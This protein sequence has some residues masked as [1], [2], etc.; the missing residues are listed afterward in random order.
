MIRRELSQAS[1][2]SKTLAQRHLV[3]EEFHDL[4][5]QRDAPPSAHTDFY[6]SGVSEEHF[7]TLLEA[8]G[9]LVGKRVLD[10]G[11]GMGET[12]RLYAEKGAVRVEGFDISSENIRVA[13]KNTSRDGLDDRVF[14][15][16]LAA[17]EIDY[18]NDSFDIVIGKAIIHHTDLER[19]AWQLNRVLAPGGMA[20]FLEPLAHNPFLNLFRRLTPSRRTPTEKPLRVED[21]EIFER[22]FSVNYRGF[23]LLT[24]LAHLLLFVTGSR[25][26]FA[27]S[28]SLL[29]RWEEPMLIRFPRLQ[30]YCWSALLICRKPMRKQETAIV[31]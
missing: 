4:K 27:K 13:R 14:F 24:L 23:Y 29:R 15:R 5:A 6:S 9:S 11:C 10:F 1:E 2:G 12:S 16:R 21:L 17:E 8:A 30:R 25:T 28:H 26:L 18:P 31:V 20:Y 3:E 19:T 7:Q 22:Y